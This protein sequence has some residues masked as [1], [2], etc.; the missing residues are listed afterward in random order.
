MPRLQNIYT[1]LITNRRGN[2][3]GWLNRYSTFTNDV[4]TVRLALLKGN[5]L[6][7]NVTYNETEF[8]NHAEPW[9]NFADQLLRSGNG[10]TGTGQSVLSHVNFERFLGKGNFIASLQTMISE[11]NRENFM[12]FKLLWEQICTEFQANQNPLLVNRT[13]AACTL[14]VT[15]TVDTS[16]FESVYGWLVNEGLIQPLADLASNWYDKNVHL[17][18]QLR[19]AFQDQLQNNTTNLHLLSIF[20]WEIYDY[21]ANP[22][23]LNRQFIK[24]GAPG[25]GKTYSAK[26][27]TKLLFDIW[28]TEFGNDAQYTNKT[29]CEIVQF[30]PSF[31]Y[32]DFMEGLRPILVDGNAQLKLQNGIFKR[33]CI[34]A[35]VWEKDLYEINADLAK[36]W[37]TLTIG[38]LEPYFDQLKIKSHWTYIVSQND[39]LKKVSDAVPPFFIIIDEINRAELSRVLGELMICLEYRGTE[40]AISTQYSA[41]NTADTGMLAVDGNFK[42][43][44]PHNVYVIGTM[45]TI[46]RSVESFDLALRRRFRWERIDPDIEALRYHLNERTQHWVGLADDLKKLN[47]LITETDLLGEDYQI[48]HAYLMNLHYPSTL[49]RTQVRIKIW[50]DNI[51]PLLEEYLRG[52]GRSTELLNTFEKEFGVK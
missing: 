30:H 32:E 31:G 12:A 45:N 41:L 46:D 7:D 39:Q 44:I 22:F 15:S 50:K 49:N 48:G 14:D 8:S 1:H 37:L 28:K 36:G 33:L 25:T 4:A 29:C 51:Q 19:E 34:K 9:K 42:F 11:P 35:G 10:V 13:L 23:S 16:K 6:I 24:Y 5:Q 17:M 38:D 21:I 3:D 43:F 47:R 27:S 20:I 18:N 52:S 26:V 40:G 2:L